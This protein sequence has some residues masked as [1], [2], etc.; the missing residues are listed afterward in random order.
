MKNETL[1]VPCTPFFRFV[2]CRVAR[3]LAR[4]FAAERAAPAHAKHLRESAK[5]DDDY[6]VRATE[7]EAQRWEQLAAA[8]QAELSAYRD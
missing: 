8:A 3:F 6:G 1:Q 7:V 5:G 4:F 2:P